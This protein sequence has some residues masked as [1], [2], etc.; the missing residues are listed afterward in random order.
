MRFFN[1]SLA[2]T[3]ACFFSK[4]DNLNVVNPKTY[5]DKG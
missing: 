4:E 1:H 5:S 2:S 3:S